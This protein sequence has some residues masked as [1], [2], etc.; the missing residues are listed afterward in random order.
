MRH[1]GIRVV[2]STQ[3]PL[4]IP[5]ELFELST[6]TV[7]HQFHSREWW[8]HLAPKIPLDDH[9]FQVIRKLEPGWALVF[10]HGT[11]LREQYALE[12]GEEGSESGSD[13]EAGQSTE[14]FV[15][16]IRE[17]LTRDKGGSRLNRQ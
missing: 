5:Q 9:S 15:C 14:T 7:L 11:N 16:R 12:W 10:A 8:N 6:V 17:R 2:V 13:E 4:T 3:S 1:E